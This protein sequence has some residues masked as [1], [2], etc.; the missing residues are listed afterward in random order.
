MQWQTPATQLWPT[1]AMPPQSYTRA[2]PRHTRAGLQPAAAPGAAAAEEASESEEEET[3]DER[4]MLANALAEEVEQLKAELAELEAK[5]YPLVE[6]Y[7]S[8]ER[9]EL[10]KVGY[11]MGD[12]GMDCTSVASG[13]LACVQR[14]LLDTPPAR[15][16]ALRGGGILWGQL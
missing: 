8:E 16:A 7:T 15:Q 1:A 4:L 11:S 14:P 2:A 9:A 3:E 6:Q 12:V 13:P 5:T 10:L